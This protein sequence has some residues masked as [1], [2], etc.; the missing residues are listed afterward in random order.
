MET[1]Y[2]DTK[3][4]KVKRLID[5]F[6]KEKEESKKRAEEYFRA[7]PVKHAAK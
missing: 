3:N 1:I 2:I 7:N 6:Q 5:F 4:P